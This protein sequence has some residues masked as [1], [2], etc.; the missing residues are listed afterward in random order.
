[1]EKVTNLQVIKQNLASQI[2]HMPEEEFEKLFFT[3]LCMD[4]GPA[5]RL[6]AVRDIFP[7]TLCKTL[8]GECHNE[9]VIE[10]EC[11]ERFRRYGALDSGRSILEERGSGNV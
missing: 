3:L 11:L 2:E 8:F 1:M 6:L 5:D 10:G 9:Q 4:V 7:C